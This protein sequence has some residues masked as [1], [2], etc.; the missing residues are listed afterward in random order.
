MRSIA[1]VALVSVL[2]MRAHAQDP[3]SAQAERARTPTG[4]D[5]EVAQ[6]VAALHNQPA[7]MRVSGRLD[8]AAAQTV[9]GNCRATAGEHG[10]RVTGN[11]C[12]T[13]T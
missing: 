10:G 3:D 11:V 13:A 8:I 6:D 9:T 12:I 7:A 2:A 5:M 1:Y 4:L